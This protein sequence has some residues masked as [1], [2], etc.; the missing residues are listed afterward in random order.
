MSKTDMHFGASPTI[1]EKARILRE[2]MT[3]AEK[4]MWEYLSNN[5]LGVRFRRQHPLGNFI[6]DFYCHKYSLI[7]EI[8]GE[9][10]NVP[11]QVT[12]DKERT[13]ELENL[14]IS[15]LRFSN[16]EVVTDIEKVIEKIKRYIGNHQGLN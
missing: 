6:A 14:G 1:F 13:L 7:I 2:N 12:Y 8:D 9:V 15:V 3:V 10:H 5:K 4:V 16:N 11:E